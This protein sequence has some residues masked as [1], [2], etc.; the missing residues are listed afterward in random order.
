MTTNHPA[1]PSLPAPVR[2]AVVTGGSRGIGRAVS[3][4]L[5]RDGLAVVVN[6]ARDAA[7]A[8][9]TVAAIADVGGRAFSAQADVADE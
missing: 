3:L 2:V 4:Q 6:Y 5:A 9:E 7:A 1:T 8:E